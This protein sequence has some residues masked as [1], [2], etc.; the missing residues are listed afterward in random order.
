MDEKEGG[1]QRRESH[2]EDMSMGGCMRVFRGAGDPAV[3]ADMERRIKEAEEREAE[4]EEAKRRKG[5]VLVDDDDDDEGEDEEVEEAGIRG[6]GGAQVAGSTLALKGANLDADGN[7]LHSVRST[8][9]LQGLS[10]RYGVDFPVN[11]NSS[12]ARRPPQ[13]LG[14]HN[15]ASFDLYCIIVFDLTWTRKMPISAARQC[16]NIDRV[17]HW[18]IQCLNMDPNPKPLNLN[19]VSGQRIKEVNCIL[20]STII[21]YGTL[22]IPTSANGKVGTLNSRPLHGNPEP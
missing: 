16:L 11:P 12:P 19:Q 18:D 1:C 9:T 6:E 22:V 20:G 4:E 13:S 15:C 10:L 7:I 21:Q 8:D 17:D 14:L 2:V 5:A 3:A